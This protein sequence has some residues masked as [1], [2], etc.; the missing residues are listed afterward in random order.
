VELAIGLILLLT[1]VIGVVLI[2]RGQSPIIVLLGLAVI[3][4]LMAGV[5]VYDL[6]VGVLQKGADTYAATI[7][8]ILFGAW[9][10]Q[11]L[12]QT[13]I[14]ESLIRSAVEL[15]GDRPIIVLLVLDVVVAI[16]FTSMYGVGAAIAVGVIALP[17]LMTM[18]V[19]P[20]L[21]AASFTMSMVSAYMINGVQFT[22]V[23]S[24]FMKNPSF[25]RYFPWLVTMGLV[26]LA[27]AMA[28]G[29]FG[30]ARV[31]VTRHSSVSVARPASRP[32]VP[33]YAYIAPLVPVIVLVGFK[34]P[35]VPAFIISIVFALLVTWKSRTL[36]GAIDLFHKAFYDAF[37]DIATI[38]ALWII[39]GMLIV[40]GQLPQVQAVFKPV[41]GP[42]LPADRLAVV[43]F[44]ALL[45]PT[46]LYR[47]PMAV[48]G[49]GAAMLAIF[50]SVGKFP[51][52]ILYP[53][54]MAALFIQSALDPTGSWSI[55][56]MSFT[57]ITHRQ[58][59]GTGLP[60]AWIGVVV[61]MA[62]AYFILP[63]A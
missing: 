2:M 55:W 19:P 29:I 4:P 32:S 62:F 54:W 15:A 23:S 35:M 42:I 10:G 36:R 37:P 26:F 6:A 22:T 60:F 17:I 5:S 12:V 49:T 63:I 13:G 51:G 46:G 11:I 44:F 52:E 7:V 48:V 30:M 59:L 18:G 45:A 28:M 56:T 34:W 20:A 57:K 3:W 58:Y 16:L 1:F 39:C 61:C 33:W 21:A 31:G 50:L 53:F 9:F 43:L 25:D 14:A 8:T 40:A 38:A 24:L 47:G 27:C 41:F